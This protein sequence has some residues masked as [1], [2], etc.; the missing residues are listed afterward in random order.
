MEDTQIEKEMDVPIE[1]CGHFR[2]QVESG[3]TEM[4]LR[5]K[6]SRVRLCRRTEE[7]DRN[8]Q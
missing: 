8:V 7:Q 4:K 1:F 6:K 2:V 5:R 3:K